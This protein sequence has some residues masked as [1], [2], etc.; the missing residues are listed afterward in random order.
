MV[1]TV[2]PAAAQPSVPVAGSDAV[3][4]VRRIWC[5]GRN[6]AE[7]AREM[8][9][10]P[11]REAPF[12]FAKPGDAVVPGGGE[13]AYPPLTGRLEFEVELAV[14]VGLG[15]HSIAVDDA[16]EHVFGYAVALDMTRRDLQAE[17]KDR[18]RPWD[19][20]KGFDMSCP[21]G[22]ITPAAMM[23][24]DPDGEISLTLDGE[25]KQFA[26]LGDM[27][28]SVAE[29]L[30]HLS[31]FVRLEPG[32]LL[33]TGTPAGVGPVRPGERLH[34]QCARFEPLEVSYVAPEQAGT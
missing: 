6:Y 14:A 10:D 31:R 2:V 11:E 27:I 19:V 9:A 16:L 21:I 25:R 23:D 5:V 26:R 15:G 4:P 13:I 8:G 7:H 29:C 24:L 22:P 1:A 3:F 30:S 32:D 18:R 12:F 17:A 20:A 28:W 33:L 34:A